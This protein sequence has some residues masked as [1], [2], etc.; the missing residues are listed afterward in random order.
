M[1]LDSSQGLRGWRNAVDVEIVLFEISNSMKPY[2]SVF[3]ACASKLRPVTGFFEPKLLDEVSNRIPPTTYVYV[4][5]YIYV[6][7]ICSVCYVMLCFS[8]DRSASD[9]ESRIRG[10]QGSCLNRRRLDTF[11]F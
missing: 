9:G 3:P 5:I 1:F 8:G 4:Y 7:F 11:R 2:P 6:L 10:E